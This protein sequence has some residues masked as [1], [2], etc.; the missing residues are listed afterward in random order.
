M[1][2]VAKPTKKSKGAPKKTPWV[3]KYRPKK[4]DDV[5]HQDEAIKALKTAMQSDNM[6]HLLFYGPP[7][8]GK[9]STILALARELYGSNFS[10]RVKEL[11]AS[12]E[13][14]IAVVRD[15]VRSFAQTSVGGKGPSFKFIILDEADSMT[16]DA[17][18]ALRRTMEKH[19]NV[20]RFCLTCN[21]VSRII[22][23]LASR[24]AKFRFKLLS[25]DSMVERLTYICK[26]EG[27]PCSEALIDKLIEISEGDMRKAIT[28][29][30]SGYLLFGD[31]ITPEGLDE[32]SGT[33]PPEALL[34]VWDAIMNKTFDD[35]KQTVDDVLADG[36]PGDVILKQFHN[37][38]LKE[39]SISDVVKGKI[40]MKVA[41]VEHKLMDGASERLQ[42]LNLCSAS[43]KLI[44]EAKYNSVEED[45][46]L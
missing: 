34:P 8:T 12:D 44:R 1:F 29:L 13:R 30:Q 40:G 11:N 45:M 17:Q 5:S 37:I 2:G 10:N 31:E 43:Y 46:D 14:G 33:I 39:D 24:C 41:I 3:E 16:P 35:V 9:T 32:I 38:L 18:A 28:T 6:P 20:T 27:V 23:P 36:F 15:K 19:A 7:G 42:I 26:K 4:M 21:Y 22:E 25:S